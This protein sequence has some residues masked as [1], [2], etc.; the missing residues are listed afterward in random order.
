MVMDVGVVGVSGYELTTFSGFLDAPDR[1]T[2]EDLTARAVAKILSGGGQ[3][4]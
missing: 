1:A 4:A 3:T 2:F